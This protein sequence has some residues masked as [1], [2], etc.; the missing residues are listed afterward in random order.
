MDN[1]ARLADLKGRGYKKS[2]QVGQVR[3]DEAWRALL[4]EV[5]TI[6]ASVSKGLLDPKAVAD[7]VASA[8]MRVLRNEDGVESESG[9]VDDYQ[10]TRKYT[11]ASQDTYFTSA[12]LRR[13]RVMPTPTAGSIKYA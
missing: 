7:V 11:D 3:L 10:E 4:L 9:S 1:P 12:E 8:A 6:P 13:M 5:P 2:P